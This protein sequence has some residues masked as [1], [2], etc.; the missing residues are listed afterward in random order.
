LLE[1]WFD[2]NEG[3]YLSCSFPRPPSRLTA[4]PE[5]KELVGHIGEFALTQMRLHIP[6]LASK[7][8]M[9]LKEIGYDWDKKNAQA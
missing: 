4:A 5:A 2:Y 1:V 7:I 8:K 9:A 3:W 6:G